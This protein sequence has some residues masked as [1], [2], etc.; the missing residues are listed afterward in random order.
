MSN[1]EVLTKVDEGGYGTEKMFRKYHHAIY[2]PNPL[3]GLQILTRYN[4]ILCLTL[5]YV[6]VQKV[7]GRNVQVQN[8][9]G[10]KVQVQKVRGRN[11]LVQNTE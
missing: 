5:A 7:R 1:E 10:R 2:E 6:L 11:V 3:K 9:K 4:K 8:V